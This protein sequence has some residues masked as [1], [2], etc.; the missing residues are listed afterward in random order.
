MPVL[1]RLASLRN[2]LF[3]RAQLEHDLDAELNAAVIDLSARFLEEGMDAAA[4]RRKAIATLGGVANTKDAVRDARIGA[5][6]ET[7]LIDL[8]Y[9]ARSLRR[10]LGLTM[11]LLITLGLGIGATVTLFAVVRT[12]LGQPLPYPNADRLVFIWLGRNQV[13]YRG[14]MAGSDLRDIRRGTSSFVGLGGVWAS[15]TISLTGDGNPEQLRAALVT[16][17]FFDVLGVRPALGRSFTANDS[18]DGA[19]PTILIGWD[20]FERRFGGDPSIVGRTIAVN[21]AP[22]TVIGVMPKGSRIL[23]PE[24]ASVPDRLQAFAPFWPNMEDGA[25]GSM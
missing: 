14:P 11:V 1:T 10:S 25:R 21:D 15:G 19:A 17:N 22:T 4:A 3:R 6:L 7:W 20:L 18:L 8:G 9:A 16:T 12:M 5:G 24:D 23:L 13:G 2:T